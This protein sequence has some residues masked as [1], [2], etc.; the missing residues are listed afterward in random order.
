MCAKQ[1]FE[2][3]IPKRSLGA[4][5]AIRAHISVYDHMLDLKTK[6]DRTYRINNMRS[7]IL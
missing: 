7:H 2:N 4:S 5:G 3:G 6:S 1:S